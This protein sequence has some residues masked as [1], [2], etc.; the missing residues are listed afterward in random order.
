ML[1]QHRATPAGSCYE[2]VSLL[3]G[4]RSG[5]TRPGAKC[6]DN[7]VSSPRRHSRL[8]GLS[9]SLALVRLD[10]HICPLLVS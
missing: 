6:Q 4:A 8:Y 5:E 3:T 9:L 2:D 7:Y 10:S 1:D